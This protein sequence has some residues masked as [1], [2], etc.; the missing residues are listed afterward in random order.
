LSLGTSKWDYA[1]GVLL[2]EEG[3]GKLTNLRGE[4]WNF[5]ENYFIASNGIVHE[6]ILEAVKD[7]GIAQ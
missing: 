2:V 5:E 3:G 1:A 4:P 6:K 7:A